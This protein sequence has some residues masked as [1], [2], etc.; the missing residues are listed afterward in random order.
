MTLNGRLRTAI[1]VV[2]CG[3]AM[4]SCNDGSMPT[5]DEALRFSAYDI[6]HSVTAPPDDHEG[7]ISLETGKKW[8]DGEIVYSERDGRF[9]IRD[10]RDNRWNTTWDYAFAYG[11]F[12]YKGIR[13]NPA[14]TYVCSET[15]QRYRVDQGRLKAI[16]ASAATVRV[17]SWNIGCFT[18]GNHPQPQLSGEEAYDE[19]C[20]KFS[21]VFNG[22]AADIVGL[23]EFVPEV[24]EGRLTAADI[25]GRYAN[26]YVSPLTENYCGK[27]L[28]ANSPIRNLNQIEL[29]IG[30]AFEGDILIGGKTVRVCI[31][32]PTWWKNRINGDANWRELKALANR[33]R[34]VENV[35]LM[36]DFNTRRDRE[37]ETWALFIDAGFTLA[38]GRDGSP[39]GL[40]SYNNTVN[41]NCVDNVL[42]KGGEILRLEILQHT[43]Q[44]CSPTDPRP[45]DERRWDAVNLSDH[46]PLIC[47]IL[48]P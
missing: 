20:R 32:H 18:N 8:F 14:Q 35:I 40:T 39:P 38:N 46:F 9:L 11:D 3:I 1:A 22:Y 42:V 33:Y 48:F 41:S 27:A 10:S 47:D 30:T 15:G 45:E 29:G 12:T 5:A 6:T 2:V 7:R 23:C 19:L 4:R 31:C 28:F 34:Y 17:M 43:P 13:P 21:E 26:A 36:G 16:G 25:L 37:D 44:G 24:T